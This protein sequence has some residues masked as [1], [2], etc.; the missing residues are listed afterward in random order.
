MNVE[1]RNLPDYAG[2]DP[3]NKIP[4]FKDM[5]GSGAKY[6]DD[7]ATQ[8]IQIKG[9]D[10]DFDTLT[11][12]L[13]GMELWGDNFSWIRYGTMENGDTGNAIGDV[14]FTLSSTGVLK[15]NSVLSY[16]TGPTTV[17]VYVSITDGKST[18]VKKTF[19]FNVEDSIG[20]GSLTVNGTAMIGSY[21][22]AAATVWQDLDNDGVKD[23]GEPNTTTN[24]QGRF[25]LA[26]TKSDQD[27]PILATGGV[28]LGSGLAN[29]GVLKIN[30][31][32]KLATDR[33]W[34]EYSLSPTSGISL[35]MQGIDSALIKKY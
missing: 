24:E 17:K 32:L 11:W 31:N 16:E 34:G 23:A 6:I 29:T 3:T 33:D 4:F 2:Y 13:V 21:A 8:E 27:A 9:F 19:Y 26:V 30:S 10:L 18:A 14:P 28:D 7:A 35:S 20:D 22:L 15:P 12:E 5:W 1:V 25:T